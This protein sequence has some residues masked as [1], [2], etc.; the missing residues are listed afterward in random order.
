MNV[1]V[2][3]WFKRRAPGGV[4]E[5]I[6]TG[7]TSNGARQIVPERYRGSE[8]IKL[9]IPRGGKSLQPIRARYHVCSTKRKYTCPFVAFLH[10]VSCLLSNCIY[11]TDAASAYTTQSPSISIASTS[12]PQVQG[13]VFTPRHYVLQ[14]LR[15]EVLPD[16]LSEGWAAVPCGPYSP[17]FEEGWLCRSRWSGC[18]GLHGSSDGV[19]DC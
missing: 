12:S 10:G 18:S 2:G 15:E 1:A 7:S 5:H 11:S 9:K 3:R 17:V 13:S 8:P 4:L 16:A 6:Y 19:L 14:G